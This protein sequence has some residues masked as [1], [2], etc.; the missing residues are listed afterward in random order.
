MGTRNLTAVFH[1]G[2]Y[3]VAQY[4]QWDGYPSGQGITALDFVRDEMDRNLFVDRLSATYTPTDEQYKQWWIDAGHD[5]VSEFVTMD[6]SEK[7]KASHPSLSRDM[8]ANIL[9][10]IQNS[11]EP[12]PIKLSINF[13]ADS[14]FCEY[15]YVIDLDNNTLEVFKGFN[16]TPLSENERFYGATCDDSDKSY[17]PIKH[18]HTFDLNNLPSDDEFLSIL[19]PEDQVDDD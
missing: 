14:L 2:E 6:I 8:A 3:K 13:A 12:V 4:G 15:A 7:F 10:Y 18:L 19:D 5:G 1:N 11:T 9:S 17:Y 16:K